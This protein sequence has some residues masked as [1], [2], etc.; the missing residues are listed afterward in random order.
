MGAEM[1]LEQKADW[2]HCSVDG[3]KDVWY[4]IKRYRVRAKL[5]WIWPISMTITFIAVLAYC[6][7][8]KDPDATESV[9]PV[10]WIMLYSNFF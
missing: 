8:T 6:F 5:W 4:V 1:T 9:A 10:M 2:F 3:Y 7:V